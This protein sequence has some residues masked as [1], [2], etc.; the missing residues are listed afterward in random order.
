MIIS[1]LEVALSPQAPQASARQAC[2]LIGLL[3][4]YAPPE[5]MVDEL[6]KVVSRLDAAF[7]DIA[8]Q[9]PREESYL[10][11]KLVGPSPTSSIAERICLVIRTY[12]AVIHR[13]RVANAA[14]KSLGKL[15]DDLEEIWNVMAENKSL[16]GVEL[17]PNEM[18]QVI[19]ELCAFTQT[20]AQWSHGIPGADELKVGGFQRLFGMSLI[21][22]LSAGRPC[23]P[24]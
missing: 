11:L 17:R 24:A 23:P 1:C 18:R 3:G 9:P 20:A 4:K 16:G 6:G 7:Q 12:A 10:T 2:D 5:D 15:T 22:A 13:L 8:E 21:D 19:T 14:D